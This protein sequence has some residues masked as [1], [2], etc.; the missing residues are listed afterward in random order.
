MAAGAEAAAVKTSSRTS[1][2]SRQE[3]D[4]SN[5]SETGKL[6][7][8]EEGLNSMNFE[9]MNL[10]PKE[11]EQATLE[12]RVCEPC[13]QS[14]SEQVGPMIPRG[15]DSE[16]HRVIKIPFHRIRMDIRFGIF[17]DFFSFDYFVLVIIQIDFNQKTTL[18]NMFET[19]IQTPN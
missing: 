13:A 17:F 9:G 2:R 14:L 11:E 6:I 8:T 18:E 1:K 7:R 10:N 4:P 3:S 19:N 12:E 16:P 15:Y 5:T